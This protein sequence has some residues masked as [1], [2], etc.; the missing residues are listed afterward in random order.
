MERETG[1]M[2]M[3][4]RLALYVGLV[5]VAAI[6]AIA[7]GLVAVTLGIATDAARWVGLAVLV[8]CLVMI[9]YFMEFRRP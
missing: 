4:C 8:V 1:R 5:V 6:L 2:R 9:V 3:V 7:A